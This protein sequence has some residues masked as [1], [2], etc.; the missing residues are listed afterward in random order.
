M[1]E[2]LTFDR[3]SS[4]TFQVNAE[5]RTIKGLA[6]PFGQVGN[7][8][9][10]RYRFSKGTLDWSRVKYLTDHDWSQAVG[11]V[12][13]EETDEGLE[14][15]AK[16]AR[17]AR[18]DGVLVLTEDQ[19]Y[20][21]LSIGL[22]SNARFEEDDEGVFNCLSATVLEVSGTPIPAFGDAQVRSVAAS[23]AHKE[24][25]TMDEN[26]KEQ[27]EA[28]VSFSQEAGDT[29]M[30]QVQKLS[31]ELAALKDIKIPVGPGSAQF[32]VTEEP[33][34][35]F[36]G[37]EGAPS[38][39]DFA[40]DLL[41]AG[42]DGD[43]AAL[44]RLKKFTAEHF[45]PQFSDQHT[46]TS[47]TAAVNPSVYRPDMFLGQAPVPASPLYDYFHKGGVDSV[48]PF[49]WSKLDR[50]NTDIGIADHT[51]DTAQDEKDLVTASGATVT[52]AAVSGRAFIT[53]EVADQGGNPVVSGLVWAEF[54][55]SFRIALET[56]TA[57]LIA[58]AS[59]TELG[60]SIT[61]GADGA[62]AGA[63]VEAGL[64][65]LQFL[66]DGFRFQR[67]FGHVELYSLL[68]AAQELVP[69]IDSSDAV[70][71]VGTGKKLYPILNP[72]NA[73]GQA[74]SKWSS[75]DIGG[76]NM[77]PA[78]ALGASGTGQKSYVADQAAVHVWNSGLSRL[79]RLQETVEGWQMAVWGY[80]A[81]IV[82]DVTGLRKVT[83]DSTP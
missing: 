31:E 74:A 71:M 62:T 50:D 43:G 37:S 64:V 68:A 76:Y 51:E 33:I 1:P 63:A 46:T 82:Y 26:E 6:V 44:D 9:F 24:E 25:N 83:Y 38:G 79:D 77:Y 35:R 30:S 61:A 21:G 78:A 12:T 27:N 3:Q 55:R 8:G 40:Q 11:N 49:F 10:G 2:K 48:T 72:R 34:Y 54:D 65:G 5:S 60:A 47:D 4:V 69:V 81:G 42:K 16:I 15:T 18:G 28:P 56:K 41:A 13:F 66:A 22:S 75:M 58:A 67:A 70:T 57:A 59:V 7:N 19:V 53:R 45:G 32:Q 73:D 36:A 20:D 39:F 17:G 23:A 29:L 14:M 52:P 80:F